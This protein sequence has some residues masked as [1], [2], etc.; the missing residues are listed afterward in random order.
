MI[1]RDLSTVLAEIQRSSLTDLHVA[2]P[3]IVQSYDSATQTADIV[4]GVQRQ[5]PDDHGRLQT[6]EMPVLPDVPVL[7]PRSASFALTFPLAP[8]DAGLVVFCDRNIGQWR[9]K[10]SQMPAADAEM[11]GLSGPVF[12]PGLFP[13]AKAWPPPSSSDAV[14]SHRTGA[15]LAVSSTKVTASNG[16]TVDYVALA[17]LVKTELNRIIGV[18]NL[19]THATAALGPPSPPI[20]FTPPPPPAPPYSGILAATDTVASATLKAD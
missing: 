20:A 2:T 11:M 19:H 1:P 6:E 3:G 18:F 7:F 4:M 9:A 12:I 13:D 8:G 5:L 10:G 17:N 16:G 15:K 14:L